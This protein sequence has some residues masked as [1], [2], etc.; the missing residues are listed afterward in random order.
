MG[1]ISIIARRV[2]EGKVEYGWSGNGGYFST[3]GS[4][5][6]EYYNSPTMV[7]Y[8][9]SLGQVSRILSPLSEWRED[10]WYKTTPT[11]SPHYIGASEEEIFSKIMFVDY[12]YFYDSDHTW[13]YV[14]PGPFCVKIPLELVGQNLDDRDQEYTFIKEV[15]RAVL[16]EMAGPY[17]EK[18]EAF[19][20]YLIECGYDAE[21]FRTLFSQLL[22]QAV[23][24]NDYALRLLSENAKKICHYFD[25]WVVVKAS[26]DGEHIGDI[27]LRPKG[28]YRPETYLW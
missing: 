11:G 23:N 18:D 3:V 21:K 20:T 2:S 28:D 10:T 7:N 27:L 14:S 17:Y 8:L 12:G 24:E 25:R 6:L 9:F 26:E 16:A 13:Y 5:L 22:A 19:R 4:A 15:E 1:D